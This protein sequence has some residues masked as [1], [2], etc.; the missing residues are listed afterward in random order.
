MFDGLVGARTRSRSRGRNSIISPH[1]HTGTTPF[2]VPA[3]AGA[4]ASPA[5]SGGR[6]GSVVTLNSH[7]KGLGSSLT[8]VDVLEQPEYRSALRAYLTAQLCVESPDFIEA[9]EAYAA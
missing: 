7:A 5:T 8:L 1:G 2:V 9:V 6:R 4:S 3:G